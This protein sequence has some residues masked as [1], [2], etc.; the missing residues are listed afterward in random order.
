[1]YKRPLLFVSYTFFIIVITTIMTSVYF[2]VYVINQPESEGVRAIAPEKV[3]DSPLTEVNAIVEVFSYACHYCEI[4]ESNIAELE[5]N[6]PAGT[7]LIRLHLS[8]DDH[9]GM[10]AFAP[11]FA[12]LTVMGIE[13]QHRPAAYQAIIKEKINLADRQHLVGW[14][15]ANGINEAA[16]DRASASAPVKELLAYMSSVSRYYQVNATPSFIVNRKW[17]AVQDRDFPAFSE[18]LLSL[19]QHDKPLEP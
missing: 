2:H 5:R 19:L 13:A 4:N 8:D 1:M 9:S 11:L 16:Y 7:R 18:Q 3:N 12:T 14:L 15:K 10:A 17:L 6:L